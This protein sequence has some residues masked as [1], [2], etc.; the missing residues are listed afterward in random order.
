MAAR[1]LPRTLADDIEERSCSFNRQPS[2]NIVFHKN[3]Y[4]HR[5]IA[6]QQMLASA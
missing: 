5:T 4:G 3:V 1:L 2:N 6:S